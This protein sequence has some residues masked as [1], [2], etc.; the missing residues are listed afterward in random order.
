MIRAMMKILDIVNNLM[1][2]RKKEKKKKLEGR[3]CAF[4]FTW[5]VAR[6]EPTM[7]GLSER[8]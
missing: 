3:G 4:I 6:D 1:G 2:E 8:D 7:V 5:N